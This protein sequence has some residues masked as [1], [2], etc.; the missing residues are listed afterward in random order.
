MKI[1]STWMLI[2]DI[3]KFIHPC[4]VDPIFIGCLM[5]GSNSLLFHSFVFRGAREKVGW[6]WFCDSLKLGKTLS[7]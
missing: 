4:Q 7:R 6:F 2:V 5:K 3:P 1:G